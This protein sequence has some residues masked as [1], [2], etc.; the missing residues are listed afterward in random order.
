MIITPWGYD[1][2]EA[3]LPDIIDAAA[4]DYITAGRW[5]G[6][7]RAVPALAAVN[8]AVRGYCGW[9]VGPFAKCVAVLDG[10][11]GDIW[12]PVP[13]VTAVSGAEVDGTAVTVESFS[14]RGRVRLA[15]P[16]TCGLGNVE[17]EFT[18]GLPLDAMPDLQRA[19]ADAAVQQ[20]AFKTYGVSQ[21]TAGDVSISYSGT[22][23]SAQGMLLPANVR[24]ALQPY[25][26]VRAHAV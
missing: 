6:D 5:H 21:E 9:H 24:A 2:D 7:A 23:L 18:A 25:R 22:A 8:A 3:S 4:F 1:V 10:E 19:I 16:A 11:P 14:R 12:L 26:V 13:F 15:S 20:I 17:V